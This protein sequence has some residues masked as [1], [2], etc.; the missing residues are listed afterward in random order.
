[1]CMYRYTQYTRTYTD[2]L[3]WQQYHPLGVLGCQCQLSAAVFVVNVLTRDNHIGQTITTVC[4]CVGAFS[5]LW[6]HDGAEA[7]PLLSKLGL[8]I[9]LQSHPL[10]ILRELHLHVGQEYST[11]HTHGYSTVCMYGYCIII[12]TTSLIRQHHAATDY[13]HHNK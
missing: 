9:N 4:L 7:V 2:I 1:M 11:I 3:T 13:I 10:H 5:G 8:G 6:H 12:V